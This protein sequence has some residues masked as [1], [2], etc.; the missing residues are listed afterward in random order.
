[1]ARTAP[2][3]HWAELADP[4]GVAWRAPPRATA[5]RADASCQSLFEDLVVVEISDT[6]AACFAA[7]LFAD[8]GATT[9]IIEPAASTSNPNVLSPA[10]RTAL[11]RNK[12]SVELDSAR[13]KDAVEALLARA[14][15]VCTDVPRRSWADHPL[16]AGINDRDNAPTVVSIFPPG[17]D[18]PDLW[19]WSTHPAF[20]AAASGLMTITGWEN[21]PPVQPE[22][23]LADYCAGALATLQVAAALWRGSARGLIIEEPMH[24]ALS[25]M[26]EWQCPAASVLGYP[27]QRQGNSL[28]LNMGVGSL[29]RSRDGKYIS[30][31]A[32]GDKIVANLLRLIGGDVMLQDPRFATMEARRV[33]GPEV[34]RLMGDWAKNYTADELMRFAIEHDIVMGLVHDAGGI[35]HD[36]QVEARGNLVEVADGTASLTLVAVTPS[37]GN[38]LG[39]SDLCS[40][41]I[42]GVVAARRFGR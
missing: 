11:S 3:F 40:K 42:V 38:G 27:A 26:I 25:R 34:N 14:D 8:Y 35:G 20:S 31:S 22:V 24:R 16:L 28:P 10:L 5:G 15:V 23:P 21:G 41:Q 9:Y 12:R 39:R 33:H 2:R 30:V 18:R 29:C 4:E 7:T 6:P 17:A 1:M 37:L 32:V 13:D 19:P 36:R